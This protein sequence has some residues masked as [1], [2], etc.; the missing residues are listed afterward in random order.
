SSYPNLNHLNLWDN[1]MITDEGLCQIAQSCNKLEYLNISYCN[2]IT[3][4]SLIKITKS[5]HNLREFYFNEAYTGSR[6]K[7]KDA[8]ILLQMHLKLEYLDFAHVMAFRN[9]SLIVAIIGSSSNLKYFDISGNNIGDEVVEAVASTCHEL[10]YLDLGGCGFITEL[11]VCNVIRSCPKLQHLELGFCDISDKTIKEIACSCPNLK[12]LDL[13]GCK[14]NVNK[15]VVKRLNP[16]I[17]IKNYNSSYEWSNSESSDTSDSDP[18]TTH[19]AGNLEENPMSSYLPP[20]NPIFTGIIDESDFI[21]AFSNYIRISSGTTD[22]ER[23]NLFNRF[24]GI[25]MC[26]S[27][28]LKKIGGIISRKLT[29]EE[30]DSKFV[31]EETTAPLG[32]TIIPPTFISNIKN[33]ACLSRKYNNDELQ[34]YISEIVIDTED[35]F[36]RTTLHIHDFYKI[37]SGKSKDSLYHRSNISTTSDSST[38]NVDST[39]GSGIEGL[40][41]ASHNGASISDTNLIT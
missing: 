13:D 32:L 23:N 35:A 34:T 30:K 19:R 24:L 4:K 18:M 7:I 10:E 39:S 20:P 21:S 26:S 25:S 29:P 12:Y 6:G 27:K 38:S 11:S 33:N 31:R 17:H 36:V 14:K 9:N 28:L 16:S 37:L 3:D 22:P 40:A 1:R 2:G 15:K 8:S 5:C 41:H